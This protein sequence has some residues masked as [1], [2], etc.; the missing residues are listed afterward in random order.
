MDTILSNRLN[1]G[2]VCLTGVE[3]EV[4]GREGPYFVRYHLF[5]MDKIFSSYLIKGSCRATQQNWNVGGSLPVSPTQSMSLHKKFS[6]PLSVLFTSLQTVSF[7]KILSCCS[8]FCKA[9]MYLI[10]P[11]P[12]SVPTLDMHL[13]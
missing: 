7:Q 12:T 1:L 6:L 5:S 11:K 2:M 8:S 10:C 4:S 3:T 13:T 9:C